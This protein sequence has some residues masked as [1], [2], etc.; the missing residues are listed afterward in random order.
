MVRAQAQ[1]ASPKPG[2]E[3]KKLAV[4]VGRF[5]NEGEVKAGAFGPNS[6]ALKV[7]GT[8]ECKWTADGFGVLCIETV[9]VGGTKEIETDVA[10]Y[11]PISKKYEYHGIRS[12]GETN[13][14]TGTVSGDVWTWV[15]E[16]T[17]GEKVFHTR[18]IMK[19]VSHD[20]YEYTEEWG[21]GDKPMKL[22]LTGSCTR[23]AASKPVKPQ[24][25]H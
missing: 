13:N 6:P 25:E 19:I 7:S 1:E 22:G 8:D 3:V 5:K 24:P 21:E 23:I 9:E 14:Q 16:G 2:P 17:L 11:D 12:T 18:Y 15:G 20:S 10:Y 4:M